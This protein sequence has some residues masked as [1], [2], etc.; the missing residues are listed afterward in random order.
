MTPKFLIIEAGVRYWEDATVNGAEDTKGDLIPF[1]CGD[2][3]CPI[4]E[5]KTGVIQG[6]PKGT[7]AD[8]HYKVCD[9][10][11]Y[12]LADHEEVRRWKYQDHCVPDIL[13][14]EKTGYGDYI[15][16]HVFPDGSI[17]SWNGNVD[18]ADWEGGAA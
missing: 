16:L 17:R 4:I 10:G 6:W 5:L 1:R 13:S 14:P 15:I 11:Q 12:W 3:W 18:L 9:A 8:V 7:E 2:E